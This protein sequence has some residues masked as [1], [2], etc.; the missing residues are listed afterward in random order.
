MS[1]AFSSEPPV[2]HLAEEIWTLGFKDQDGANY[3]LIQ[4]PDV[5]IGCA[6][7]QDEFFGSDHY[8]EVNDQIGGRYGGVTQIWLSPMVLEM[9]LNFD[10]P[11]GRTLS[12]SFPA[13]S[14]EELAATLKRSPLLS[15]LELR[16]GH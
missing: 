9:S 4:W 6:P 5:E 16:D 10:S 12:F 7:E 11:L 2:C 1:V 8:V 3:V 15:R 13:E 14:R